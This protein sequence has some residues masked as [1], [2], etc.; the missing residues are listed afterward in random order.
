MP[1]PHARVFKIPA[2]SIKDA[3]AVLD[4]K[5]LKELMLSQGLQPRGKSKEAMGR[6]LA[7]RL[8]PVAV[9]TI[10]IPSI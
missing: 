6:E 2:G 9:L 1:D 10:M 3:L 7:D 8:E 4:K 5:T